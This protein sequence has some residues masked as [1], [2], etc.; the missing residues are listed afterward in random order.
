MF[1]GLMSTM[2]KLCSVI[3]RFHRL[4]LKSSADR[5]VC[6]SLFTEIELMWYVCA[7]ANTRLQRAAR[8]TS[9]LVTCKC[10]TAVRPARDWSG[11]RQNAPGAGA[12]AASGAARPGCS[13]ARWAGASWPC[14][15]CSGLPS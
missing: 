15:R 6:W 10:K 3:S 2:L 12:A 4:I 13:P 14:H 5:N 7:F 1:A 9:V 11:A 8:S